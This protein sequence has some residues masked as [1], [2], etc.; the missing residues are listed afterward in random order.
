MNEKKISVDDAFEVIKNHIKEQVDKNINHS[1]IFL[2][3]G[4]SEEWESNFRHNIKEIMFPMYIVPEVSRSIQ[5]CFEQ[6][7]SIEEALSLMY[8]YVLTC[9]KA[10]C[11]K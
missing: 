8:T 2:A 9:G 6:A 10:T 5:L 4:C 7:S 1:N 3:L 11:K